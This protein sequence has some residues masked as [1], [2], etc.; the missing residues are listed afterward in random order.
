MSN[1]DF[2]YNDRDGDRLRIQP[3]FGADGSV[4]IVAPAGVFIPA[5]DVPAV[6]LALFEKAGID[7]V[8]KPSESPADY[9][10]RH[11]FRNLQR[12]VQEAKAKAAEEDARKLDEEALVLYKARHPEAA[13]VPLDHIG[14][15]R[16]IARA[17]RELYAPKAEA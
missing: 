13:R 2:T 14:S 16:A 11:A 3:D 17:A 10:A 12:S 6:A 9:F 1:A 5:A 4:H 7:G 15:Y 8:G